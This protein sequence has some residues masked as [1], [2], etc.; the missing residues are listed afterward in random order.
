MVPNENQR[1]LWVF[2]KLGVE[3][4]HPAQVLEEAF[5]PH[6]SSATCCAELSA[7]VGERMEEGKKGSCAKSA[8]SGMKPR[9]CGTGRTHS[10]V[11][12]FLCSSALRD[13]G[14]DVPSSTLPSATSLQTAANEGS[15]HCLTK[16]PLHAATLRGPH[17]ADE[18]AEV[19]DLKQTNPKDWSHSVSH[20]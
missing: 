10:N 13:R 9:V 5:L 19:P 7:G 15:P 12:S 2:W 6:P 11:Q 14:L 17:S 16:P 1:V 8:C 18:Q 4:T 20:Y 3:V